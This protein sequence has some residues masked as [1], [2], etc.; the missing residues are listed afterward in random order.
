MTILSANAVEEMLR[1]YLDKTKD[2]YLNSMKGLPANV[3][4]DLI[5]GLIKSVE[6]K[7]GEKQMSMNFD[8][9]EF[10]NRVKA[11]M[12][13]EVI[14]DEVGLLVRYGASKSVISEVT[15]VQQSKI[16]LKRKIMNI[17]FPTQG[18]MRKLD[19]AETALIKSLWR[20]FDGCK[21]IKLIRT[22]E[23]SRQPINEVWSVVRDMKPEKIWAED[24]DVQQ[25][26]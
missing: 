24:S 16:V 13:S 23:Y 14:L 20:K 7:V 1:E 15:G 9:E 11:A 26:C 3:F 2:P 10:A 18:R 21:T 4:N 8:M 25:C 17:E 5:Q 19:D 6:C 22:H 12:N